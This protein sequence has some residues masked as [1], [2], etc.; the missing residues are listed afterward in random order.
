MRA[1]VSEAVQNSWLAACCE[2]S[3]KQAGSEILHGLRLI[4]CCAVPL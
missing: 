3:M 2:T 1:C 4:V